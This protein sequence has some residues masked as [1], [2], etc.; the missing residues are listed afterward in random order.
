MEIVALIIVR[1][2]ILSAK[3]EAHWASICHGAFLI[4]L[5]LAQSLLLKGVLQ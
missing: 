1:K 4:K 2:C 5:Q 3:V